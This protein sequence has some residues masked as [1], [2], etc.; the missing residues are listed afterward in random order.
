MV[1]RI[2]YTVFR[3]P[4]IL[5]KRAWLKANGVANPL[6]FVS[7][8]NKDVTWLSA[9]SLDAEFTMDVL[10]SNAIPCG[11]IFLSSAPATEQ[12]PELAKWLKR[13][14][15]ILINLGSHT[16]YTEE[17]AKEIVKAL[18]TIFDTTSV[19]VLWKFSKRTPFSNNFLSEVSKEI[20]D[21]RLRL[22]K[23][24]KAD[25][26]ALLETGDII[27]FVHHGGA[28]CYHEAVGYVFLPQ[29]S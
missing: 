9:G 29:R 13:A 12:D 24:L 7:I 4:N 15:T 17:G 8:Y 25:P 14:P 16:D 27:L 2:G 6:S 19:Q 23:W 10:P 1:A 28:N 21:D 22:E 26:A 5:R 20:T 3:D 18:K 11:P